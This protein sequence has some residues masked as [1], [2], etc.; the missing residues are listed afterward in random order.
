MKSPTYSVG[1]EELWSYEVP[2]SQQSAVRSLKTVTNT[3][4]NL[5]CSDN[6]FSL[7]IEHFHDVLVYPALLYI[8]LIYWNT[9][10]MEY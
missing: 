6:S 5:K 8:F 10:P 1:D 2:C 9:R 7:I 3:W 4:T